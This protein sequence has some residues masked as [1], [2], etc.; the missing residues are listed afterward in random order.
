MTHWD[1]TSG[2]YLPLQ[3]V[4][5]IP[6]ILMSLRI[7]QQFFSWSLVT[8]SRLLC[9]WSEPIDWTMIC[10]EQTW[11]KNYKNKI[12]F[13]FNSV[14]IVERH[15]SMKPTQQTHYFVI[16]S[17]CWKKP[18]WCWTFGQKHKPPSMHYSFLFM[19]Y[20]PLAMEHSKMHEKV[21]NAGFFFR[22]SSGTHNISEFCKYWCC[23]MT[24]FFS[25]IH[26]I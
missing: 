15:V 19:Q 5:G 3:C 17:T 11:N 26:N 16:T 13:Q 12:M 24:Q 7:S 23:N 6:E 2:N 18:E 10:I 22:S 20:A 14:G 4:G 21:N 8:I 9:F 25:V 1:P